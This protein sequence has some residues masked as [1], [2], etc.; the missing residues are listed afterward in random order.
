MMTKAD[1]DH[2]ARISRVMN[3]PARFIFEAHAKPEHL[4]RWFGPVGYPVTTCDIDFRPGGKWRMVMTGPDGVQGP[5][6]WRH[7]SGGGSPW[8]YRL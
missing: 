6:V 3:L 1:S 4:M 5:T 7:L 2:T 8:P